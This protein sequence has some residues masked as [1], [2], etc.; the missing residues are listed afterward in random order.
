MQLSVITSEQYK[1]ISGE[2]YSDDKQNR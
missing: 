1:E 2:P